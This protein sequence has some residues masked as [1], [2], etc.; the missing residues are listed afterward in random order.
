M[1]F[2]FEY[3]SLSSKNKSILN[4]VEID[5]FDLPIDKDRLD[6]FLKFSSHILLVALSEKKVVGQILA[7]LHPHPDSHTELFIENLGVS[8][9]YRRKGIG[10]ALFNKVLAIGKNKGCKEFWV[11]TE[12]ENLNAKKFYQSLK[13]ESRKMEIY[14]GLIY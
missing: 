14:E 10:S 3:I 7:Y 5:V 9:D 1:E 2:K 12:P 6:F 11:G 4:N 13:L 8:P